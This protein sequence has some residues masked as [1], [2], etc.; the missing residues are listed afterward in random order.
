MFDVCVSRARYRS[1]VSQTDVF[2][3]NNHMGMTGY[4]AARRALI[5][6]AAFLCSKYC[7][8]VFFKVIGVLIKVQTKSS[9]MRCTNLCPIVA[10]HLA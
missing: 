9:K 2:L 3:F 8:S 7:N 6:T 10:P 5:F 4:R 1:A